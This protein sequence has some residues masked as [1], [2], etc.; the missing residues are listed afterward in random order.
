MII[1]KIQVLEKLKFNEKGVKIIQQFQISKI[2]KKFCINFN[3]A[4]IWQ[5]KFDFKY[6][7]FIFGGS[8]S[9]KHENI[10]C[11]NGIVLWK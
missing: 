8:H 2:G 11:Y 10:A 4:L 5:K 7:I 3:E 9:F 1:S 6:F